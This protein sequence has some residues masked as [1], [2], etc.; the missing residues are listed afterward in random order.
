MVLPHCPAT[1]IIKL[2]QHFF[3]IINRLG[4]FLNTNAKLWRK[5]GGFFITHGWRLKI[6]MSSH[7]T[8]LFNRIMITC[9]TFKVNLISFE[10]YHLSMESIQ[11]LQ[12][13]VLNLNIKYVYFK[14]K[15]SILSYIRIQNYIRNAS[16][17]KYKLSKLCIS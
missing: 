3:Q 2:W 11:L 12:G 8:F 7:K 6:R 10:H 13:L 4:I 1:G 17:Q 9:L 15:L 14:H 16:D 5:I